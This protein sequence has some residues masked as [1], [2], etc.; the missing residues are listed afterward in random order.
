MPI[1]KIHASRR[2]IWMSIMLCRIQRAVL[3]FLYYEIKEPSLYFSLNHAF[4]DHI[5]LVPN[6]RRRKAVMANPA[7]IFFPFDFG[8]V[9]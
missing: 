1:Q 3:V 8:E 5:K 4:G 7:A 2:I 6:N 9:F